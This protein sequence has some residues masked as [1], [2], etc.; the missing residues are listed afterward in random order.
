MEEL[1]GLTQMQ[2][3][4]ELVMVRNQETMHCLT[5]DDLAERI[6]APR[7]VIVK[8]MQSLMRNGFAKSVRVGCYAATPQGYKRQMDGGEIKGGAPKGRRAKAKPVL[9]KTMRMRT[10]RAI[11]ILRRATLSEIL[12][13]AARPGDGNPA[14]SASALLSQLTRAGYV[15]KLARR[16]DPT[17]THSNGEVI[18]FLLRSTGPVVPTM[19]TDKATNRH[20]LFDRNLEEFFPFEAAQTRPR[21]VKRSVA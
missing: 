18:Y 14:R 16:R 5:L 1:A 21:A 2:V 17:R 6:K 15:A 7:R 11:R 20:G 12:E 10:W 3:L 9:K 4:N 8:R 13:C 19:A